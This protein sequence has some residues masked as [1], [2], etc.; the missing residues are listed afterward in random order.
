M[1]LPHLLL[2]TTVFELYLNSICSTVRTPVC[3]IWLC[4]LLLC[5]L[6]LLLLHP[7]AV[8]SPEYVSAQQAAWGPAGSMF[9]VSCLLPIQPLKAGV[10]LPK[11]C[12]V[13]AKVVYNLLW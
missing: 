13:R 10:K 9:R 7:A 5:L 12:K 1:R 4:H 8:L 2:Y 11:T 6:L 3:C